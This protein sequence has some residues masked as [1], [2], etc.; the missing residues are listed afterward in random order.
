MSVDVRSHSRTSHT[1]H[2]WH[3]APVADWTKE[4]VCQWLLALGLEQH[5]ACFLEHQVG[6]MALLQLDSRDFKI[7]GVAGDDKTRL[8][9]KLKD[10]KL[11]VDK[12]RRQ[13]EKE[14]KE[15]DKLLRKQEKL[16]KK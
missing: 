13:L 16:K 7:L 14:R 8:K 11:Q 5:I 4:Q 9:R 15:R 3:N 6:G 10:L 1:S 12:E 2:H